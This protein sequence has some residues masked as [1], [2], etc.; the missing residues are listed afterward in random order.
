[1]LHLFDDNGRPEAGV[2]LIGLFHHVRQDLA[3]LRQV[4][5][6]LPHCEV[7]AQLLFEEFDR[8]K[9]SNSTRHYL[10]EV[11]RTVSRF[12]LPLV[13]KGLARLAFD[14]RFS[15][16]MRTKFESCL[17]SLRYGSRGWL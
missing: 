6:Y 3:K 16:R 10:D 9:S 2:F 8:V 13:E 17:D 15:V 12:P 7:T 5:R 1:V 14:T 11:L 4:I